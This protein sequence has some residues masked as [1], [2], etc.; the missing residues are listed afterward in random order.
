MR[1]SWGRVGHL[2]GGRWAVSLRGYLLLAPIAIV[3]MILSVPEAFLGS[4]QHIGVGALVGVATY[5]AT[6][7]V[8]WIASVSL[9]RQ[10]HI[11][12]VPVVVVVCVGGLSWAA[13]SGLLVL[14]LEATGSVSQAQPI[15]RLVTGFGLGAVVVPVTAWGLGSLELF[16][17]ERDRLLDE[18]VAVEIRGAQSDIYLGAMRQAVREEVQ[19]GVQ[20]SLAEVPRGFGPHDWREAVDALAR[21]M[22]QDLPRTLWQ[23]ARSKTSV[24]LGLIGAMIVK[25]PFSFWPL[26][27]GWCLGVLLTSRYWGWLAAMALILIPVAWGALVAWV[28]NRVLAEGPRW[29]GAAYPGFLVALGLGGPLT[30]VAAPVLLPTVSEDPDFGLLISLSLVIFMSLG[31]VIRASNV[32]EA[33]VMEDLHASISQTEVRANVLEREEVRLRQEIATHLHSTL[34]ANL[35]AASMRLKQA[36][37]MGQVDAAFSAFSEVRRLIEIDLAAIQVDESADIEALLAAIVD[38]WLGLVAITYEV[39]AAAPVH[40]GVMRALNDVVGEGVTNAVRH[41]AAR[42]VHVR[43]NETVQG[44]L[45]TVNDDGVFSALSTPGLG[46]RIMDRVAPGSW[47]RTRNSQGGTSLEVLLRA[48]L[49]PPPT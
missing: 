31:G 2:I 35:T 37:S 39:T 14:Y 40:S 10:R 13:R 24:S 48:S 21:Q 8:Q 17:R 46:S 22:S 27:V 23:E 26:V 18:L 34:G 12:P 1:T 33:H 49:S 30:S 3:W 36:I 32:A 5:A 7:V 38:S 15:V 9:L 4:W 25:R 28:G 41:G 47:H 16:R 11:S 19:G 42:N 45:I 29:A 44:L 6:G 20:R 43:V